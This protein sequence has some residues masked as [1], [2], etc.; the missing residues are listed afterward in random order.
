[1]RSKQNANSGT[2][3]TASIAFA[4]SLML[5]SV[6][7]VQSEEQKPAYPPYGSYP[8]FGEPEFNLDPQNNSPA[9]QRKLRDYNERYEAYVREINRNLGQMSA[10]SGT[11][12][13]HPITGAEYGRFHGGMMGGGMMGSPTNG[14]YG[15]PYTQ[16]P[17]APVAVPEKQYGAQTL[18]T[19]HPAIEKVLDLLT[20]GKTPLLLDNSTNTMLGAYIAARNSSDISNAELKPFE[21]LFQNKDSQ[22][23]VVQRL[24]DISAELSTL[25]SKAKQ[26][27]TTEAEQEIATQKEKLLLEARTLY[28]TIDSRSKDSNNAALKD[29]LIKEFQSRS[30]AS[31][32]RQ[33]IN[34]SINW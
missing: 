10:A 9:Y 13:P 8:Y 2:S 18:S 17:T 22:S 32:A 27:L 15:S 25:D 12:I 14:V 34:M 30:N 6:N 31:I 28:I 19:I 11:P 26:A 3:T 16:S 20:Q 5:L 33:R 7:Y 23:N 24:Q 1:M 21:V 4:F 29:K